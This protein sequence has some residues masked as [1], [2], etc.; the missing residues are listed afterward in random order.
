[1]VTII[2]TTVIMSCC[3]WGAKGS[4]VGR[5]AVSARRGDS[6]VTPSFSTLGGDS[7]EGAT[8]V[9][10]SVGSP[11]SLGWISGKVSSSLGWISGKVSCSW[12]W[13]ASDGE[14]KSSLS[15]VVIVVVLEE[16][17]EVTTTGRLL[18]A[19]ERSVSN[20]VGVASGGGGGVSAGGV[21]MMEAMLV[22]SWSDEVSGMTGREERAEEEGSTVEVGGMAPLARSWA[23]WMDCSF[24]SSTI[25]FW[26]WVRS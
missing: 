11:S 22:G 8:G 17:V 5:L 13:W 24:S 20:V 6:G 18:A 12:G 15:E 3:Y 7:V 1:M 2:I 26:T 9:L 4:F 21:A 16:E 19:V 10:I 25:S 14:G 23:I